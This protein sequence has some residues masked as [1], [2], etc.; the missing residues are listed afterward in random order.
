[1]SPPRHL[2]RSVDPADI[3]GEAHKT[4][5]AAEQAHAVAA[6]H[7]GR[8]DAALQVRLLGAPLATERGSLSR[9]SPC[10]STRPGRRG[11]RMRRLGHRAAA[12][13]TQR[14]PALRGAL[15]RSRS[16]GPRAPVRFVRWHPRQ[17]VL[18]SA[19]AAIGV[20]VP[21]ASTIAGGSNG[22]PV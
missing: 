21:P 9:A 4:P 19:A 14:A 10:R 13:H 7:R 16:R 1:V 12:R 11:A 15:R 18:A 2:P 17:A 8:L 6:G 5:A 20:W 22:V 3:V